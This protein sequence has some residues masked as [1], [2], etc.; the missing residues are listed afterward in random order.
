MTKLSASPFD[1][2]MSVIEAFRTAIVE[3]DAKGIANA[4][5]E[6]DVTIIDN[7]APFIWSGPT[8]VADWMASMSLYAEERGIADGS[9]VYDVP[10]AQLAAGDRAYAVF[11]AVWAYK[12]RGVSTR[13]AATIAF[14]LRRTSAG[15]RIAG[16]SW[17]PSE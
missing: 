17:N 13:D 2:P 12:A 1:D 3:G 16:W 14:A 11:P 10:I 7:V 8:A 9:V 6:G 5:V 4:H 15:W